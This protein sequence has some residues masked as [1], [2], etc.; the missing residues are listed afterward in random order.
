MHHRYNPRHYTI[1]LTT[2]ETIEFMGWYRRDL[3]ANNWHYY[4]KANGDVIH[5]RKNHIVYVDGDNV[6]SIAE[7]KVE[8][9]SG[10]VNKKYYNPQEP[11]K[12]YPLELAENLHVNLW[13]EDGK[14]KWSIAYFNFDEEGAELKFVSDRPF[15]PRVNWDHFHELLKHGQLL[16]DRQY[17][18]TQ[19]E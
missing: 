18:K 5:F 15:D 14:S 16:A 3:E 6:E 13:S 4:E 11:I 9:T 8:K 7:N 10:P 2:Y 17:Y 12:R 19:A 1:H